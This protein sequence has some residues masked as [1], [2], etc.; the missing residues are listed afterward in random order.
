[1]MDVVCLN[2]YYG[3]YN[4]SGDLDAACDALNTELDFWEKIGKPVMFTEYGADTYPGIHNTNGE[5]FSEEFQMDYF[6]RLDA[7]LDKRKFFIGEQIWNFADF[8]TIQ[9]PMRVDGNKKGIL[10]RDRRP[11]LAAHFLRR[12]WRNIPDFWYKGSAD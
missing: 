1:M 2:R 3:W 4:L 9:G 6:A 5:M 11:K 7:Q 12:R 10:T 8:S